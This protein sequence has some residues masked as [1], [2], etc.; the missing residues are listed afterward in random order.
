MKFNPYNEKSD[1]NLIILGEIS[2]MIL[3]KEMQDEF[4]KEVKQ[5]KAELQVT[6]DKLTANWKQPTLYA[7]YGQ[8]IDRI[9][10]TAATLGFMEFANYT[11][12]MKDMCYM[13][14][15]SSNELA[16]KKVLGMMIG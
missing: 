8:K 6:V 5:I 16:Q 7:E 1:K 2:T 15:N 9:Y 13:C 4:V 14:S 12:A 10:G 11:K 3:D